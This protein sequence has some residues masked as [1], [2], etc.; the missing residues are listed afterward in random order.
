MSPC[1]LKSR[2]AGIVGSSSIRLR[3][4]S[5]PVEQLYAWRSS[6][7]SGCELTSRSSLTSGCELTSRSGA[8]VFSTPWMP[9]VVDCV[10]RQLDYS[11]RLL[12]LSLISEGRNQPTGLSSCAS[13]WPPRA[14]LCDLT[15]RALA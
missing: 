1:S 7:T 13:S 10:T 14:E 8:D 11:R 15:P 4:G 2:A 5:N 12:V 6:L 9:Y 3:L